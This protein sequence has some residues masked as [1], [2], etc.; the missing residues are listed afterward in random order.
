MNSTVTTVNGLRI[1][2][3]NENRTYIISYMYDSRHSRRNLHPDEEHELQSYFPLYIVWGYRTKDGDHE[4]FEHESTRVR[5]LQEFTDVLFRNLQQLHVRGMRRMLKSD[6][7][8]KFHH[9]TTEYL[10]APMLEQGA[11][12]LNRYLETDLGSGK[13]R[14]CMRALA[15]KSVL[16][17][18]DMFTCFVVAAKAI[19]LLAAGEFS[20][21]TLLMHD[22]YE[23][24][25]VER[26]S[27]PKDFYE[28]RLLQIHRGLRGG[29]YVM[30]NGRKRYIPRRTSSEL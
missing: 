1:R 21:A 10:D 27:V 18:S 19:L 23:L 13:V 7:E 11:T 25:F 12:L 9:A 22:C 6:F 20:S 26:E 4:E 5:W 24:C 16:H 28:D 15:N 2:K 3:S 17:A 29:T 30:L 14:D 8:D